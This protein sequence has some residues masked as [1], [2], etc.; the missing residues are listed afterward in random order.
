MHKIDG[1]GHVDNTYTEGNPTTGTPATVVTADWLNAVQTEIANVI[2]EQGIALNKADNTQLNAAIDNAISNAVSNAKQRHIIRWSVSGYA[3]IADPLLTITPGI[4]C[5][6]KRVGAIIS[7]T[8]A[9]SFWAKVGST[10]LWSTAINSGGGA[11]NTSTVY[12]TELDAITISLT[13]ISGEAYDLR[14]FL[15]VE[16]L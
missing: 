6:T 1:P 9:V 15:V 16:E 13:V 2:T 12:L 8:G 11:V 10:V 5:K 7:G 14:G 3:Q 4:S